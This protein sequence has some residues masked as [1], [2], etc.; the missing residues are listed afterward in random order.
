MKK[1]IAKELRENAAIIATEIEGK[2]IRH[3][4]TDSFLGLAILIE[5]EEIPLK[6]MASKVYYK[7]ILTGILMANVICIL[8]MEVV[9]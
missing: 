2:K 8:M 7:G 5:E 1:E 3:A 4:L 6:K 9:D